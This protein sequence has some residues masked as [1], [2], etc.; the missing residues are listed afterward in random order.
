MRSNKI[1]DDL[2]RTKLNYK[3]LFPKYLIFTILMLCFINGQSQDLPSTA[4]EVGYNY[5]DPKCVP[6]QPIAESMYF[7]DDL[8]TPLWVRQPWGDTPIGEQDADLSEGISIKK[9][10]DDPGDRLE[11]AYRDLSEFLAAG[12][13]KT[14]NGIYTIETAYVPGMENEAFKLEISPHSCRI[15]A[16]DIEGIRRGIFHIEDAMLKK[17][18]PYLPL[19]NTNH[20]AAIEKRIIRGYFSPTKRAGSRPRVGDEPVVIDELMNEIDYYPDEYLNRLAHQGVNG[21]WLSLSGYNDAGGRVGFGDLVSTSITPNEG[22]NGEKRLEK[23]RSVVEKC[24]RYGI[25]TYLFTIEPYVN[26]S[27][28]A[29]IFDTYKESEIIGNKNA[30]NLCA[31]T[32]PGQT[33]LY[34]ATNK[35]FKAIPELG[36]LINISHGERGTTCL[37]AISA[38]GRGHIDCPRCSKLPPWKIL[39]NALSAM[40]RGIHD[41]APNAELISWLYMP[42]PQSQSSTSTDTLASWVYDIPAHTPEGVILQFNFTSGVERTAFGKKLIGGDYWLSPPGPSPR[43]ERISKTGMEHGTIMSA[44]IQTGTSHEVT[45]VPYVPVPSALYKKFAAM[46]KLGVSHTMLTWYFGNA[47]GMMIKAAGLLSHDQLPD[48]ETFLHELA[49]IYWKPD[50]VPKVAAAWKYFETGYNNYPLTNRFQ[51]YGPMHDGPVWPL[52]LS[53][54]DAPLS[55]TWQLVSSQTLSP[56]PPSGDR[57]GDSFTDLLSLQE[58]VNL[59]EEM[60][61]NWDKGV[62]IMNELEPGY[63]NEPD[64]ILDIGLAKAIGI[65]FRSGYNILRFYLLREKMLKMTGMER[66]E[67]LEELK[68]II[69]EELELDSELLLL[70]RRDSRL[71]YHP[72]AEGYKYYPEKIR[73][74]MEQLRNVLTIDFPTVE[75]MIRDGQDLFPEYTGKEPEGLIAHSHPAKEGLFTNRR[76]N[77]VFPSGLNWQAFHNGTATEMFKWAS[78]YDKDGLY[79]IAKGSEELKKNSI[80]PSEI[81][82]RLQPRRLWPGQRFAFSFDE[83]KPKENRQVIRSKGVSYAVTYI[84][85]DDMGADR[86]PN[87]I[88]INVEIKAEEGGRA[89]WCELVGT[90]SRLEH[91]S[92]NPND[93]GWLLLED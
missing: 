89:S 85:W 39:S 21:L 62:E 90:T 18:G 48:E 28:G 69:Y 66:L 26:L 27:K 3:K 16:T 61:A 75:Q 87:R 80:T 57:V 70:S 65:Q 10:F 5:L 47:P 58:V 78:I 7:I 25:K 82:V 56:W 32:V 81:T 33:Y 72:E 63:S 20:F 77:I 45:T 4:E 74:R 73:W 34:E 38:T 51:Y 55:P 35:I 88:R 15:L 83:V 40:E 1:T 23:L 36:G 92:I 13:V 17:R 19:G 76:N 60:S 52:L 50:D 53:P 79:I 8:K 37:S 64:R 29:P 41:A 9:S 67:I 14:K 54:K 84:P 93:F 86:D 2:K 12:N 59:C 42:Q 68:E 71:G 30:R 6:P 91:G 46:R 24:L 31:S 11:T 44:K 43:Y 22:V 49:S